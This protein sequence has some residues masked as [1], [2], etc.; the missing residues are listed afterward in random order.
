MEHNAKNNRVRVTQML[1]P[2]PTSNFPKIFPTFLI[3]SLIITACNNP[4]AVQPT[5]PATPAILPSMTTSVDCA[6]GDHKSTLI[7]DEVTRSYLLH[8][9]PSYRPAKPIE[10]ILGFGGDGI[11]EHFEADSALS[12]LGDR[13]GFMVVYP[14][15]RGNPPTWDT[16][17]DS[18]DVHFINN[19][20]NRLETICSIDPK[21]IYA[22][23]HSRGGSM[24]NR[25]ACD[26]AKRIAAIAPLSGNY[27]DD[28]NCSP[29]QPVAVLSEHGK[30]DSV[31]Y[32]NGIPPNGAPPSSYYLIGPPIPQWA[33]G[34]AK[35]N[36]CKAEAFSITQNPT[37]NVL[38]WG[39]C[40]AGADVILY[41]IVDGDHGY[42]TP[43]ADYNPTQTILDFFTRHPLVP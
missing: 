7:S 2:I 24:A 17:Q 4:A 10:L 42:P 38:H 39:N 19:L 32:Y 40:R 11:A 37:V 41:T 21:R 22:V 30:L 14:Q 20:I 8:V 25:L 31:I 6:P 36:G 5:D 34:W 26:L 29:S 23:G 16:W 43:S 15:G 18:N 13:Q 9:P 1:N 35:R 3:I 28:R 12:P 27:Q 33:A